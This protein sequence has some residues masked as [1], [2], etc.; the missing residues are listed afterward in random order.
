MVSQLLTKLRTKDDLDI[1]R[2]ELYLLENSLYQTTNKYDNTIRN[3]ISNWVSD[4]LLQESKDI[5]ISKYIKDLKNDLQE[6]PVLTASMNFEPSSSFVETVS[7]WIKGN[8]DERIVID[9]LLNTSTLGGVQLSY[10]GKY[11]DLSLRKRISAELEN[12]TLTGIN[13]PGINVGT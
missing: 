12:V 9:I 11:L 13:K 4:I 5:D 8:V 6:I 10:R 2:G 7:T 1:L 3:D